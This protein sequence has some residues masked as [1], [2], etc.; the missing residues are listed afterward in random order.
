MAGFHIMSL[1]TGERER[2]KV[3]RNVLKFFFQQT[4]YP[5]NYCELMFLQSSD[6]TGTHIHI[7]RNSHFYQIRFSLEK[8]RDKQV[9]LG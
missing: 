2:K 1:I 4:L 6:N 8:E 7:V 5:Y 3:L 9:V